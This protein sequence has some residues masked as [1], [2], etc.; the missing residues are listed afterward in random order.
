MTSGK[1]SIKGAV[2]VAVTDDLCRLV[3]EGRLSRDALEA[4]LEARD[5][6]ILDSKVQLALWYPIDSYDRLLQ[7]LVDLEAGGDPAGFLRERGRKA[8]ARLAAAGVYAQLRG[9]GKPATL[10]LAQVKRTLSLWSA[11][12]NFSQFH[13]ELESQTPR[14]LRIDV[15]EARKFSWL[16]RRANWGFLEAVFSGL[17]QRPVSV[18]IEDEGPDR[19]SYRVSVGT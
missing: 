5:L 17:A 11:L 4:R 15:T 10:D 19:F 8:A 14:V 3:E 13:C 2:L 1:E 7:V 6:D 16:L 9:D 12:V 18:S